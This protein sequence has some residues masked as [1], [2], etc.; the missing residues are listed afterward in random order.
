MCECNLNVGVC[1][2]SLI[3]KQNLP[4]YDDEYKENID[5]GMLIVRLVLFLEMHAEEFFLAKKNRNNLCFSC[6]DFVLST[7]DISCNIYEREFQ[8]SV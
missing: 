5:S 2:V 8:V 1:T 3:Q 6:L 7:G 4:K